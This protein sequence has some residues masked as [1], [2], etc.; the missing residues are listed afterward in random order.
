MKGLHGYVG[1]RLQ[2]E[3]QKDLDD[4]LERHR[5]SWENSDGEQ[6]AWAQLG[7]LG[8]VTRPPSLGH[9][10]AHPFAVHT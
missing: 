8:K 9:L 10:A 5:A 2:M 6:K 1:H 7:C 3:K 4:A